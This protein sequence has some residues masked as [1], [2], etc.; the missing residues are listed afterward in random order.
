VNSAR[1]ARAQG[2]DATGI[3]PASPLVAMALTSF[4]GAFATLPRWQS[5]RPNLLS[6]A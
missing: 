5:G 2:E 3:D 6:L 1:G 4:C